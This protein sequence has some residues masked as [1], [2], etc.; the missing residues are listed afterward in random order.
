MNFKVGNLVQ[1][2]DLEGTDT[3]IVTYTDKETIRI[4]WFHYDDNKEYNYLLKEKCIK[5][6]IVVS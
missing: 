6:F 3:G 5:R 2:T 4:R 1:Y